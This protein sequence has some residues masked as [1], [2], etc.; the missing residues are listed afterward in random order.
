MGAARRAKRE[1]RKTGGSD[2][3]PRILVAIPAIIFAG[4]IIYYGGWVF[5]AGV[6]ALAVVCVHELTVMFE[7][8]RPVRLAAMIG[9]LGLVVA[10]TAGDE[11]QVMLAFM[12]TVPLT[13]A[14]A[15]A[16]PHRER[17]TAS[18]SVTMLILVWIGL[19]VAHAALLRGLDHG[20]A[21]VLL[22]LLGTFVGDTFAYFGGRASRPAQA[23]ADGSRPT[24]PSRAWCAGSCVGTLA[25]W[26]LG[27]SYRDEHWF[28]GS[29]ACCSG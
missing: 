11:T 10:G 27:L 22:V 17:I 9:V 21:L 18:I 24:R 19:G 13:F 26:Y 2:L 7:R 5:A 16:S 14:L 25:V 6:A 20:G 28:T 29:T 8:A 3:I 12:A 4:A 23:R 1:P 15:V